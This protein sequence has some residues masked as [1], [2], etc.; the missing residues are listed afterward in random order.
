MFPDVAVRREINSI[1][2]KCNQVTEGCAW[3]GELRDLEVSK[4][5]NEI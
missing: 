3:T 1:S 2:V 4:S 5:Y